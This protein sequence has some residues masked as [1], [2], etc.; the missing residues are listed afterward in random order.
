MFSPE[1]LS[2]SSKVRTAVNVFLPRNALGWALLLSSIRKIDKRFE[3]FPGGAGSERR[4][5]EL[6]AFEKTRSNIRRHQSGGGVGDDNIPGRPGLAIEDFAD[7]RGVFQCTSAAHGFRRRPRN[8]KIFRCYRE[9][10][11]LSAL[12]FR[13]QRF[14]GKRNFIQSARSVNNQRVIHA[15]FGERLREQIDQFRRWNAQNLCPS[16]GGIRQRAKEI[17][18]RAHSKLLTGWS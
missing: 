14:R 6:C 4:G 18:N 13:D 10:P 15:K 7:G 2:N 17:E 8:S 3:L 12:D 1:N 9:S 11:H 5:S 16:P